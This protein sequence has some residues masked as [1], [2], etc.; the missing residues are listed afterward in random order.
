LVK[1]ALKRKNNY[2]CLF[3]N[4]RMSHKFLFFAA[5][6]ALILQGFSSCTT[7]SRKRETFIIPDYV[8]NDDSD[9]TIQPNMIMD[10]VDNIGSPI[11]MASLMRSLELPFS[12]RY[13][14]PARN[15]SSRFFTSQ[16]KAF[17]LGVFG[18]NLGYI[19]M[20]NRVSIVLDYITAMRTL[21]DGIN[22]GQFFDFS[23]L[24]RIVQSNQN[25]DSLVQI[26]QQSFNKMSKYLQDYNRGNLSLLM[27]AGV[28]VEGL[29]LTTQFLKERPHERRLAESIGEQKVILE[30]LLIF[31]NNYDK[32][33]YIADLIVQLSTIKEIYD[34]IEITY[35]ISEP[36]YIE[37]NGFMTI[38]QTESSTV[39]YTD[40]QMRMIIDQTEIVRNK[41]IKNN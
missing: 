8:L 4:N 41:M 3:K 24:R 29:Y 30:Q 18:C 34:G 26:S 10:M 38:V 5:F 7:C 20:Y 19:N 12:Q 37:E 31:L 28:W 36:E 33:A 2:L 35:E 21:A 9:T 16:E 13:L 14:A 1:L 15:A 17:N 23:T 39:H 25:V 22:V 11:E 6:V 40:E 32:D 27:V